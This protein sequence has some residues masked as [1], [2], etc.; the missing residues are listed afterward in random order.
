M[1]NDN[2]AQSFA[3][4]FKKIVGKVEINASE[5][6]YLSDD[7]SFADFLLNFV[8]G[9]G[10]DIE[11]GIL[12]QEFRPRKPGEIAGAFS[13]YLLTIV[14][15]ISIKAVGDKLTETLKDVNIL[16]SNWLR[17]VDEADLYDTFCFEKS[18]AFNITEQIKDVDSIINGTLNL[19]KLIWMSGNLIDK[20]KEIISA[21]PPAFNISEHYSKAVIDALDD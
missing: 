5:L 21:V 19:E 4:M 13:R 16:L 10:K 2:G 8:H 7:N 12:E 20:A 11:C 1:S 6:V 18:L 3:T 15:N 9:M 17:M 14:N